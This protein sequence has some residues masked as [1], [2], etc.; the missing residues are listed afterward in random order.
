MSPG[1][2][3][4]RLERNPDCA[5]CGR[6]TGV[7][8]GAV[9]GLSAGASSRPRLAL[10]CVGCA[11]V[12]VAAPVVAGQAALA[13]VG[14]PLGM[15]GGFI[16]HVLATG[17]RRPGDDVAVAT[18]RAPGRGTGRTSTPAV[19]PRSARSWLAIALASALAAHLVEGAL[20]LPTAAGELTFWLFLGLFTDFAFIPF[21]DRQPNSIK[22]LRLTAAA[23]LIF[24]PIFLLIPGFLPKLAV[25]VLVNFCNTGWYSILQGRL[26]S[27]LP[28]QSASLM[29]IG[30]VT[31]PIAKAFPLIIGFLADQ[32]GLA[33]AMWILLLGPIA[34]LVGLPKNGQRSKVESHPDL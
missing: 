21:I 5:V 14:A 6:C 18:P 10:A 1:F 27:A 8:G 33:S 34:L 20:G 19:A 3:E 30:A 25:I 13:A 17:H 11:A 2:E 15:V 9:L 32:F 4:M 23:Q 24:F 26:Y 28:G 12:G 7:Y 22:F 29:A 31:T 16:A